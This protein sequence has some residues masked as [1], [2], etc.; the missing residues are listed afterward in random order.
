M[1]EIY[2]TNIRLHIRNVHLKLLYL[3]AFLW[4]K[5]T[6]KLMNKNKTISLNKIRVNVKYIV[7]LQKKNKNFA[8]KKFN[9][10]LSKFLLFLVYISTDVS[11]CYC[12]TNQLCQHI[13]K[14]GAL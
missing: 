8:K 3:V 1:C 12:K 10:E 14:Y 6:I 2:L 9:E 5:N 13:A 7:F 4:Y 11:S